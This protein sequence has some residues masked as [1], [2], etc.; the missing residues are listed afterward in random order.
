M[1]AKGSQVSDTTLTANNLPTESGK[2][3]EGGLPSDFG[4]N[5]NYS[6]TSN[7]LSNNLR[8]KVK[9]IKEKQ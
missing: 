6:F 9:T 4:R 8:G 3:G 1:E 7:P 5:S 2:V